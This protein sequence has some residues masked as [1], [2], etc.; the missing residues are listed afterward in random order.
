MGERP[1][2]QRQAETL[3]WVARLV[4][5]GSP[6]ALKAVDRRA[7][8]ECLPKLMRASGKDVTPKEGRKVIRMLRRYNGKNRTSAQHREA[9][10]GDRG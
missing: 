7:L 3:E 9:Q 2:T 5:C 10:G 4:L 8:E 1:L 6:V